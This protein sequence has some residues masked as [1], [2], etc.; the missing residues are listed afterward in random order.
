MDASTNISDDYSQ[1]YFFN[2]LVATKVRRFAEKVSSTWKTIGSFQKFLAGV[3]DF[4]MSFTFL[5]LLV[6]IFDLPKNCVLQHEF[7]TFGGKICLLGF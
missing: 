6:I 3:L 4:T 2:T 7:S 5:L 1:A